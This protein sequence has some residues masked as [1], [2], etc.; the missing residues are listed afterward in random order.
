MRFPLRQGVYEGAWYKCCQV[1]FNNNALQPTNGTCG[2]TNG[3]WTSQRTSRPQALHCSARQRCVSECTRYRVLVMPPQLQ[4]MP[5]QPPS[6]SRPWRSWLL[7]RAL[8]VA[9]VILP[10]ERAV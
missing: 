2:A 1:L 3:T 10:G 4:F 5:G 6:S 8:L 7:P 9:G